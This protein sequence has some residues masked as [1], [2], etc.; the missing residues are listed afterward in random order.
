MFLKSFNSFYQLYS[1]CEGK[2]PVKQEEGEGEGEIGMFYN[3]SK[4]C[5]LVQFVLTIVGTSK[6][7][8]IRDPTESF[9]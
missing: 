7:H 3:P 5:K 6:K 8:Y 9:L 2:R 1:L 4:I